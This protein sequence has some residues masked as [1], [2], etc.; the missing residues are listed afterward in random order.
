MHVSMLRECIVSLGRASWY[1]EC[2]LCVYGALTQRKQV[3]S[4]VEA[5]SADFAIPASSSSPHIVSW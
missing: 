4:R 5:Y 2:R 3:L 1:A